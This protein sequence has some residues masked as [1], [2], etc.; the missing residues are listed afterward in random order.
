MNFEEKKVFLLNFLYFFVVAILLIFSLKFTLV[1][2]LPF[3][4]GIIVAYIIQKPAQML[5]E[6]TRIKKNALAAILS[7]MT[8]V[9]IVALL[10]YIIYLFFPMLQKLVHE[11]EPLFQTITEKYHVLKNKIFSTRLASSNE[12]KNMVEGVFEGL[13]EN[14]SKWI[15]SFLSNFVTNVAKKLPSVFFTSVVTL[16]ASFYIAKDYEKLK[17]F[18]NNLIENEKYKKIVKIKNL[19]AQSVIKISFGYL[20]IM[21]ITFFELALGLGILGIK[22]FIVVSILIAIVDLLPVLGIGTVLLPWSIVSF[23]L[24][25]YKKGIGLLIIYLIIGIVRNIIEPKIISGQININPLFTLLAMFLG[26]KTLGLFGIILFPII[27]IVV[28][29]YYKKELEAETSNK[30]C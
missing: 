6:K 24:D 26:Y 20:L 12:M 23:L 30:D 25:D 18:I 13:I 16:V 27:L 2:L 22:S 1:Y 21:L 7:V 10:G 3:L 28:I 14:L 19:I 17:S 8:Y 15:S 4:L 9:F 5:S 29:A 11:I